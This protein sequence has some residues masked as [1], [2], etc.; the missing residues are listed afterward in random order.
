[1]PTQRIGEYLSP[2]PGK[3]NLH[4]DSFSDAIWQR[5][6]ND[7][8]QPSMLCVSPMV[9]LL[10]SSATMVARNSSLSSAPALSPEM[11]DHSDRLWMAKDVLVIQNCVNV[12]NDSLVGGDLDSLKQVLLGTPL[13]PLRSLLVKLAEIPNIVTNQCR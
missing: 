10:S 8:V 11:S 6:S 1:M 3:S 2:R 7:F 4:Q 12:S 9:F 5:G 13:G